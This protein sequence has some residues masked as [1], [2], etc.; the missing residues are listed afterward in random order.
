MSLQEIKYSVE[1][2]HRV[3]WMHKGYEV[4]KDRIGQWHITCL[5]NQNCIGLTWMDGTTMNGQPDDFFVE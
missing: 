3:F 4:K 2:G 1:S 5:S